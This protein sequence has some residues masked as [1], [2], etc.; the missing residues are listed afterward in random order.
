MSFLSKVI[1]NFN[2]LE[3]EPF[4]PPGVQVQL[5]EESQRIG[6]QEA[7][8]AAIPSNIVIE[9]KLQALKLGNSQQELS[10][11][12]QEVAENFDKLLEDTWRLFVEKNKDEDLQKAALHASRAAQIA[13]R[14]DLLS[15]PYG[16]L[17]L[18]QATE[19]AYSAMGFARLLVTS[20]EFR[21]ELVELI[22]LLQLALRRQG[23]VTGKTRTVRGRKLVSGPEEE[24]RE[25]IKGQE[26]EEEQE[27][28]VEEEG[29]KD[30]EEEDEQ[31]EEEQDEEGGKG[32]EEEETQEGI[33]RKRL[34]REV[35]S[36]VSQNQLDMIA[37][38]LVHLFKRLQGKSDVQDS[39]RFLLDQLHMA[40]EKGTLHSDRLEQQMEES[41]PRKALLSET[42]RAKHHA[43]RVIE[44]WTE[45]SL[46]PLF[47][48]LNALND[49][50]QNDSETR[51][52][53]RDVRSFLE[54]NL[55]SGKID[56]EDAVVQE[57][58][59]HVDRMRRRLLGKREEVDMFEEVDMLLR[60]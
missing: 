7:K 28:E 54:R 19:G 46:D 43:I 41:E 58:K 15:S 29:K 21:D 31:E 27:D 3:M 22:G 45:T 26:E 37:R 50:I 34:E 35:I 49:Q 17:T 60:I 53:L 24:E 18:E 4:V 32:G 30:E 1:L 55:Q 33:A 47:A 38:C 12:G 20:A 10:Q 14:N 42:G 36:P 25:V 51:A 39:F 44:S 13:R 8:E 2:T 9:E 52:A 16:R 5:A 11:K 40:V 57:T 48:Q 23:P 56:D 6:P 59:G